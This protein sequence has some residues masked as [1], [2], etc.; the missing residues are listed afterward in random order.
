MNQT[1]IMN[2]AM[3]LQIEY[4][5]KFLLLF[6]LTAYSLFTFWYWNRTPVEYLAQ[7][8]VSLITKVLARVWFVALPLWIFF[9]YRNVPIDVIL[10]PLI[11]TYG[12][13]GTLFAMY[14][15]VYGGEKVKEF[16][17]G[18]KFYRGGKR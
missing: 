18:E 16:F 2:Y 13:A 14:I 8:Y 4:N 10:Q 1:E 7:Y 11:V 6:L 3:D 5:L 12:V 15:L 17:T 9:L